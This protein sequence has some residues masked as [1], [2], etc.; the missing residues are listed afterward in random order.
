MKKIILR[1][2][3]LISIILTSLIIFE[4]SNQNANDSKEVSGKITEKIVNIFYDMNFDKN[5]AE[6]IIRKIAHYSI[7]TLLGFEI[8]LFISTFKI[9]EFDRISFS[10]IGG[11]IYAMLDEIHQAFV[12][13]RGALITDVILDTLGVITGIFISL[14]IIKLYKIIKLIK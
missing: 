9:K 1:I 12:P 4:F 14:L 8:M 2:V 3:L 13:G 11:M 7:Y 6:S 5:K 10:L